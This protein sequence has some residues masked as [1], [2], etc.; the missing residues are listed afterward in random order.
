LN[1]TSAVRSRRITAY[2][3]F[4]ELL[5]CFGCKQRTCS[6]WVTCFREFML[7]EPSSYSTAFCEVSIQHC[8]Q[9]LTKLFV[10]LSPKLL[11]SM[12]PPQ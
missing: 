6:G 1:R 3:R 10:A 9:L 12:T 5:F 8:Y 2:G 4:L 7:N 11:P